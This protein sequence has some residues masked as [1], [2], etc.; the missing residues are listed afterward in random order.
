MTTSSPGDR[1]AVAS[2]FEQAPV[3]LALCEG[4]P[5]AITACNAM[6][7]S[8]FGPQLG[9]GA[10]EV[11]G[12]ATTP[13]LR[14]WLDAVMTTGDAYSVAGV[15]FQL[16][17]PGGGHHQVFLDLTGEPVRRPDG[18][19]SGVTVMAVDSTKSVEARRAKRDK[20]AELHTRQLAAREMLTTVQ[21][22]LLP[23]ALPV[24]P[25]ARI[26]AEYLMSE[27][28]SGGDW[29]DAIGLPD[30][31]VVLTVGDVVGDGV[32]ASVVMGEIRAVFDERIRLDG[33]IGAALEQLDRRARRVTQA[34][35][36]TMCVAILD[37]RTGAV[38]YCTAGHPPPLAL[39]GDDP[40]AYLPPTGGRP[41]GG[42]GPFEV[43]EHQLEENALLILYSNGL[44]A[45][46]GR[47]PMRSTAEVMRMAD[48]VRDRELDDP[49]D[50]LPLVQRVCSGL[51]E[52]ASREGFVDDITLLAV[53]RIAPM[54]A[55]SV[56][57]SAQSDAPRLAR[58]R[59]VEWLEPL[60]VRGID[61]A[62]L[63]HSVSELVRNAVEHAYPPDHPV[64][65]RM[66][67]LDACLVDG[68]ALEIVVSDRGRWQEAQPQ[69]DRGRGLAMVQGLC[70]EFDLE[71]G[72]SG[73]RARIRHFP[74][75][76]A[77]LLTASGQ[78]G[79]HGTLSM[80][81]RPGEL[82]LAGPVDARAADRLRHELSL[83]TR[84]GTVPLVVDLTEVTTLESIG[85][86]VLQEHQQKS[87]GLR[88]VAPMG[89]PAQH[90]L[91]VVQLPYS[92]T[93]AGNDDLPPI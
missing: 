51:V 12:A 31:R 2:A 54:A 60:S 67:A 9:M 8:A 86:Q 36:T 48:A 64:D 93:M 28:A 26:A 16:P 71:R 81:R 32:A 76:P 19:V 39:S 23:A 77:E 79:E 59:L 35:G 25:G 5:L 38:S 3:M 87:A 22:A 69:P 92:P 50:D 85:V 73:T 66:V 7:R 72:P 46:Q 6:F 41:L 55:L 83:Q 18:A 37:P 15:P 13:G 27:T 20:A 90:V 62:A 11:M 10:K 88:L 29:F 44:V 84:G 49:L 43:A 63:Q 52:E 1:D 68:G 80:T 78:R 65:E 47:T 30:G 45:R 75:R 21:D 57:M 74:H 58:R 91:D 82:A 56:R 14:D 89:T 40:A 70:D 17:L 42:G 53:Q 33:D 24:L 61:E 4:D 34:R